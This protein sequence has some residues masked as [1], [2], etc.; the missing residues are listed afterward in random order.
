MSAERVVIFG[1]GGFIGSHL[2]E[3]L[4]HSGHQVRVFDKTNCNWRNLAA[5]QADVEIVEGDFQNVVDVREALRDRSAII[6]LVSATLPHTSN[7]NPTYDMESNVVSSLRLLDEA[8]SLGIGRVLFISSGGTIY[9]RAMQLPIPED[10]PTDP[11]C[12]YGIGKL[13]IEKYLALYRHLHGLDYHV[14]RLSN[15]YGERQNPAAAQ[16]A[17][18]VFLNRVFRGQPIE[19]WGTGEVVRD[20]VYI[21]DAVR[22][23]RLV[24][25][26]NPAERVFNVGSGAGTSINA[27]VDEIAATT[28]RKVEVIRKPG[29]PI[30][31]PANVLDTG[32]IQKAVGWTCETT[33]R[34]GL[35]S[36]W[37]WISDPENGWNDPAGPA[38]GASS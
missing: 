2:A 36:T 29:R 34:R 25:E 38:G 22:A 1:G 37:N 10:H 30:D 20:Y 23:F 3:D 27:L 28:G 17:V 4:V 14:L 9:G 7:E 16:G 11:L 31:V 35:E 18:G 21:R 8:R 13:A 6:H 12:S 19:I 15:P 26:K 32:R 5:V 24:L 33:L